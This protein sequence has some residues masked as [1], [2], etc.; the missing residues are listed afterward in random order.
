MTASR[1]ICVGFLAELGLQ[2]TQS[3]RA[4]QR[5]SAVR[6]TNVDIVLCRSAATRSWTD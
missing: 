2:S 5:S 1:D 4:R 6:H 3:R